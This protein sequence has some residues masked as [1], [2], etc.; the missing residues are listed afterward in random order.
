MFETKIVGHVQVASGYIEVGD[1]SEV[2]LELPA[3][4]LDGTYPV[5]A[6]K[7]GGEVLGYFIDIAG[8][9]N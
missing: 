5:H 7:R 8:D 6:L 4:G 9:Q 3:P 1:L 2:Q